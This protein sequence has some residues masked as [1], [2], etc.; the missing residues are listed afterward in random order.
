MIEKL[1]KNVLDTLA[2]LGDSEKVALFHV[3][4]NQ[5]SGELA[6]SFNTGNFIGTGN[7]FDFNNTPLQE[8]LSSKLPLTFHGQLIDDIP[9]PCYEETLSGFECLCLPLLGEN[10]DVIGIAVIAQSIGITQ[11][12]YRL[13]T[14]NMLRTL[15][16]AAMENARLF[17]LATT[18]SLTGLYMRRY[19]DIRLHEE[20]LRLRRHGG[21]LALLLIDIDFFKQVNDTYGHLIGDEVLKTFAQLLLETTR[22]NIDLPCRFGGEEFII[23]LPQTDLEGALVLAERIR[24]R[25]ELHQFATQLAQPLRVT[26][27][28]GIA[29]MEQATWMPNALLIQQADEMLY[30]AKHAGRNQVFYPQ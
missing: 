5:C 4:E 18:D 19:F 27:S 3:L 17:E 8:V 22:Q 9:F 2:G 7:I 20:S 12:D 23:L 15:I 10:T 14:L 26:V 29:I 6:G 25:C 21:N 24:Q 13:R 1:V 16:A 30:A 28:I 11:P